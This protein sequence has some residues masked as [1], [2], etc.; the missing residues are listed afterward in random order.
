[1]TGDPWRLAEWRALPDD[2]CG[3]GGCDSDQTDPR[4]P[5]IMRDGS[6]HKVCP[7]H[8][9]PIMRVVGEQESWETTDAARWT[10]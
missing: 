10:P 6:M 3:I 1:V 5:L 8:W 7:A 2:V 9:E 4:G